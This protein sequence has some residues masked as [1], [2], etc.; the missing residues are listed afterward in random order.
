MT[1]N[2]KKINIARVIYDAYP[3]A[4]LLPID[5]E[6]DCRDLQSLFAKVTGE[7]IGDSLFK[8]I[9]IEIVEGG[10]CTVDGAIQVVERAKEDVEAVLKALKT[11]YQEMT[12]RPEKELLEA[13]KTLTSYT[14]DLLYRLD[15]QVNL[16]DVE[17]IQQAKDAIARYTRITANRL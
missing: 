3:H 14:S 11:A 5:A 13:C 8:F 12:P 6:Q 9:V 2:K 16:G 7:N 4:D 10:E 15:D 1:T 17:E